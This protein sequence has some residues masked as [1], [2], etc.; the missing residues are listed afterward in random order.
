MNIIATNR[1][2]RHEYHI[3]EVFDAGI[4]LVGNEVKSLRTRSCS[5]EGA[6][7]ILEGNEVWLYDMHIP[8]FE[9]ASVFKPNAKRKRKLLLHKQEIKRLVGQTVLKGLTL[10]PLKVYFNDKGFAKVEIALARGKQ[11]HDKR[12]HI[13]ETDAEREIQRELKNY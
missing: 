11:L 5:I 3:L 13:K 7:A 4:A 2:A 9:K 8:E 10:V 12:K 6:F 1:K